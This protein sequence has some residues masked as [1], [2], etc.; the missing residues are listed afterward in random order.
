[1][2]YAALVF[3]RALLTESD[4]NGNDKNE[5]SSKEVKS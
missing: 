4:K 2:S 1:M 5:A 3:L